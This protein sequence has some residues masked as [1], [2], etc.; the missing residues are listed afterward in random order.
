M[1]LNC[2]GLVVTKPNEQVPKDLLVQPLSTMEEFK[3]K[4]FKVYKSDTKNYVV[5][6]HWPG[7]THSS[8][9]D[10]R[11]EPSPANT[12]FVG[13]LNPKLS[14]DVAVDKFFNETLSGGVLCLDVGFGKTVTALAIAGRLG[15][16]TMILVHKEFLMN[17]WIERIQEFCPW[18]TY[19]RVQQDTLELDKDFVIG[20][21]QTLSQRTFDPKTFSSIGLL[22]VDEAHHIGARVFSQ[23]MFKLCP[24]WTLGLTATPD[25][26]DGLGHILNWFLGPTFFQL[27]REEQKQVEVRAH[28]FNGPFPTVT[29][30]RMG[31]LSLPEMV[32][33]LCEIDERNQL[34]EKIVNDLEPTRQILILSD[35]RSHC[36]YFAGLFDNSGL[37]MG[38]MKRE[39]LENTAENARI[40]CATFSQAHEGLDIPKLDTVI[41]ATPHSDVR[42]A[43]GRILRETRGKV[44]CP[45]IIDIVDRWTVLVP[46][47]YKRRS[48]YKSKGFSIQT[49]DREDSFAHDSE[50]HTGQNLDCVF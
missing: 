28:W 16:R 12:R 39:D 6:R 18:S 36:E 30:N 20:M 26:K 43:T 42:Q 50:S 9:P 11:P 24:K 27:H 2:Q 13:K 15:L 35:R 10:K 48:M 41:L 14:Q 33:D 44:N 21:I 34:I 3:P 40:I 31:K 19:G 37:Y 47:Y 4:P 45:L 49:G 22:I 23:A 29:I 5:P 7:P 32:T 17:Q 8:C 46:M 25:R 38:G 1:Y